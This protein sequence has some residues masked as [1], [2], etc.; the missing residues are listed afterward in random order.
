M[1][2]TE[3][4]TKAV[5]V[6]LDQLLRGLRVNSWAADYAY[7]K[8]WSVYAH[9]HLRENTW[10]LQLVIRS[11]DHKP[12][13]G[14]RSML[15]NISSG[16][17]L[18]SQEET[19]RYGNVWYGGLDLGDRFCALP[20][21]P[22]VLHS[23]CLTK[24]DNATELIAAFSADPSEKGVRRFKANDGSEVYAEL[25]EWPEGEHAVVI[26][27]TKHMDLDGSTVLFQIDQETAK[28]VLRSTGGEKCKATYHFDAKYK[29]IRACVPDFRIIV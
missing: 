9:P 14:I 20:D 10:D 7:G 21:W 13:Q 3:R 27:H 15:N 25:R 24:D 1:K 4:T 12:V 11:T 2:V 23:L 19:N 8:F 16:T 6:E 17:L 22:S 18:P 28:M 29:D 5:L 26:C